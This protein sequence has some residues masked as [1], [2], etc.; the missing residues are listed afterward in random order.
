[1]KLGMGKIMA[2]FFAISALFMIGVLIGCSKNNAYI[3]ATTPD[4]GGGG[5]ALGPGP[6][7]IVPGP[8][9]TETP[10]SNPTPTA[11]ATSTFIPTASF[12]PSPSPT[13]GGDEDDCD[14]EDYYE[15]VPA[16]CVGKLMTVGVDHEV[17]A[18]AQEFSD[19]ISFTATKKNGGSGGSRWYDARISLGLISNVMLP[20]V[21]NIRPGGNAGNGQ[22]LY[23]IFDNTVICSY[24]S[25]TGN[26]YINPICK[27]GGV[28]DPTKSDG[29]AA[30]L[31]SYQSDNTKVANFK[32]AQ[33]TVNGASGSGVVTKVIFDLVFY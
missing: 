12:T 28:I 13:H 24:R 26:K 10:T 17:V 3:K 22:K 6:T 16:G 8:G 5:I 11:T 23:L 7:E 19:H 15:H 33:V 29:F 20:A 14:F 31:G 18:N 1:M 21:I 32:I 4:S 9:V 27:L 30:G 2:K 25:S